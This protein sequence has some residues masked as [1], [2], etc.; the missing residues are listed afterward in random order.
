M[1]Q[2]HQAS[3]W[4][5]NQTFKISYED[6]SAPMGAFYN[7]LRNRSRNPPRTDDGVAKEG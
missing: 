6:L 5:Q 1:R 7:D 3:W 2:N 4:P